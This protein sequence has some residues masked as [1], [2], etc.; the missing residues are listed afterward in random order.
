ML[1]VFA[2]HYPLPLV[3]LLLLL[4]LRGSTSSYQM[5]GLLIITIAI[6][7][8]NVVQCVA[9]LYIYVHM[10]ECV[11]GI[12][13]QRPSSCFSIWQL[14]NEWPTRIWAGLCRIVSGHHIINKACLQSDYRHFSSINSPS[15]QSVEGGRAELAPHLGRGA[16]KFMKYAN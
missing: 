4:V 1:C 5:C 14:E 7:W 9:G 13:R 11:C 15:L 12:K 2:P 3:L 10:P 8:Q 16:G 6:E